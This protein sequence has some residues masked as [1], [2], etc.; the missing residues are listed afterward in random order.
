MLFFVIVT[1]ALLLYILDANSDQFVYRDKGVRGFFK[2]MLD[3]YALSVG[4]FEPVQTAFVD[5]SDYEWLFWIIFLFGTLMSL[6]LLLN[7]VIAVMSMALEEVVNESEA[8]VNRE[9]LIDMLTNIHMLP[10]RYKKQFA[11]NK[12][13]IVIEVDP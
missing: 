4:D 7:M 2:A 9:K 6:I 3:S 8:L 5:N 10:K 12:Y 13:L 1:Q 11:D